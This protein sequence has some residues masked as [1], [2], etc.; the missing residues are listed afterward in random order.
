MLVSLSD[1]NMTPKIVPPSSF[2]PL[3]QAVRERG[4]VGSSTLVSATL[5]QLPGGLLWARVGQS[6]LLPSQDGL[7]LGQQASGRM[8]LSLMPTKMEPCPPRLQIR[9]TEAQRHPL[10]FLMSVT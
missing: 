6:R 8:I 1:K 2:A 4:K 3:S 10:S 7:T 5:A 9:T